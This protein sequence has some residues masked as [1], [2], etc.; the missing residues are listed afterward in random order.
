LRAR[1]ETVRASH[2]SMIEREREQRTKVERM[3]GEVLA[4]K[5]VGGAVSLRV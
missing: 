2:A 3:E 1:Y 5:R 4:S